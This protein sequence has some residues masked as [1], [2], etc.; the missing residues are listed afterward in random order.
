[1]QI[2]PAENRI[3][4][5][6]P[7]KTLGIPLNFSIVKIELF[8]KSAVEVENWICM[9]KPI[10]IILADDHSVVTEGIRAVLKSDA[11]YEVSGI[12]SNA[13]SVLKYLET[14]SVDM[15]LLDIDMPG[16]GNFALL[17]Q[18]KEKYP[19]MKVVIFTMYDGLQ[20]FFDARKYGADSYV[21]KSE[22]VTFLPS[23]LQFAVKG[24]FY[25]SDELKKYLTDSNKKKAALKPLEL[26][27]VHYI[28]NGQT[29]RQI[30]EKIGRTEKTVEYYAGR[31]R[32]KIG[33][34]NNS[35]LLTYISR[36][37]F[38]FS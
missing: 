10:R 5:N 28:S 38:K 22:S 4:L 19:A 9:L 6:R 34:Q 37:Y 24:T 14:D 33:V 29:Y 25:C 35:E 3:F 21:L 2:R 12:F 30:G 36:N 17:K 13:D 16:A 26:E 27:I 11:R 31:I 18:I 8:L 1:M 7:P 20:Y 32:K 23:V 15:I